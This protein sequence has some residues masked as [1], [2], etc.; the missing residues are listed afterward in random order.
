M[1]WLGGH[2]KFAIVLASTP[3]KTVFVSADDYR[4]TDAGALLLENRT[5]YLP[6]S[7]RVLRVAFASGRWLSIS[8]DV[9][10]HDL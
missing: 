8:T 1:G 2:R 4:V 5:T 9:P 7:P 6:F 3:P 10:V